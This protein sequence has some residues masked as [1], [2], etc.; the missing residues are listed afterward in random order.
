M[1]LLGSAVFVSWSA[2]SVSYNYLW[3]A[4]RVIDR[5][6]NCESER[7]HYCTYEMKMYVPTYLTILYKFIDKVKIKSATHKLTSNMCSS[8][9]GFA[10]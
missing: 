2:I 5:I 4:P 1:I 10:G 6:L 3:I 9:I 8:V 7:T